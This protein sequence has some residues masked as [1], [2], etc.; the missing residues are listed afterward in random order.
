MENSDF[1][2]TLEFPC[3]LKT[4]LWI[5][6]YVSVFSSYNDEFEVYDVLSKKF[7]HKMSSDCIYSSFYAEDEKLYCGGMLSKRID[8]FDFKKG[9][10]ENVYKIEGDESKITSFTKIYKNKDQTFVALAK[11]SKLHF[12]DLFDFRQSKPLIT[13]KSFP[14]AVNFSDISDNFLSFGW[15]SK[16]KYS[17]SIVDVS[18]I[19]PNE[20]DF[21]MS[22]K[23]ELEE[24]TKAEDFDLDK[25]ITS[26]RIS[27][28][29]GLLSL[30]RKNGSVY[31]YEI[32][33]KISTI[34]QKTQLSFAVHLHQQEKVTNS[35]EAG[36]LPERK[37]A[38]V[39][40]LD[41]F[42]KKAGKEEIL[43]SSGTEGALKFINFRKR[44]FLKSRE[45][46]NNE[47]IEKGYFES[48]RWNPTGE[49]L[50]VLKSPD[51]SKSDSTECQ[52]KFTKSPIKSQ[53]KIEEKK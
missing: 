50:M 23:K 35:K 19:W 51:I 43:V 3:F 52:M 33:E 14:F 39:I 31:I 37:N 16:N 9:V 40:D 36:K 41:F 53:E 45:I 11:K 26:I 24:K 22:L 44:K 47:K 32:D 30:G 18:Q 7:R 48:V 49:V 27:P 28:S 42:P 10:F 21:A 2:S 13:E 17:H 1:E 12:L 29:K 4:F 20:K 46:E 38:H 15:E 6:D 5:Q 34:S 25:K 8:A